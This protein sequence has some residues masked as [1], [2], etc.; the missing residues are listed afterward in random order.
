MSDQQ[1]GLCTNDNVTISQIAFSLRAFVTKNVAAIRTAMRRFARRRDLEPALHSLVCL[2]F[3]HV[4]HSPRRRPTTIRTALKLNLCILFPKKEAGSIA[5]G[6]RRCKAAC[7]PF[8]DNFQA[9]GLRL[10]PAHD[11]DVCECTIS[12]IARVIDQLART[13]TIKLGQRAPSQIFCGGTGNEP[14]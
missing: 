1:L 9:Q 2:L 12:R 7:K 8:S 13:S 10:E 3:G 11:R 6:V 5:G 14:R 4:F